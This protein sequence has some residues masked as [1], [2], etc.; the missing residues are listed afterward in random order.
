M[1]DIRDYCT[2][3]SLNSYSLCERL[4]DTTDSH[5]N[6]NIFFSESDY[7][8]AIFTDNKDGTYTPKYNLIEF[9]N[10]S[11]EVERTIL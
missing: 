7:I 11:E 4:T 6:D 10:Y 9:S 8:H 2:I 1:Y 3:N 5:Y